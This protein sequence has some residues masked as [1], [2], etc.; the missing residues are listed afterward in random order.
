MSEGAD[1]VV[2]YDDTA[3]SDNGAGT[4]VTA[5]LTRWPDPRPQLKIDDHYCAGCDNPYWDSDDMT[6]QLLLSAEATTGLAAALGA[7][8]DGLLEAVSAHLAGHGKDAVGRLADYCNAHR[9]ICTRFSGTALDELGHTMHRRTIGKKPADD[10]DVFASPGPAQAALKAALAQDL[11]SGDGGLCRAAERLARIAHQSQKDKAGCQYIGHPTRVAA[12]IEA[13]GGL[14][15]TVAAG[16]L[17]D[18]V[19]DTWVTPEFLA[20]VG[21]PEPVIAA[22]DAATKRDGESTQAYV[23]RIAANPRAVVVKR[24][25][26][27]DNTDPERLKLVDPETRQRLEA[28]YAAFAVA[29]DTAFVVSGK[30]SLISVKPAS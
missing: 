10:D 17:H 27:A 30:A 26:L 9:I 23:S 21:F 6:S 24:A 28:K 16:W 15:E 8:L 19:E 1:H 22:V 13:I 12:R 3:S 5:I 20:E 7:E 25:D 11:A 4:T 29:L 14:V 2:L 18:V